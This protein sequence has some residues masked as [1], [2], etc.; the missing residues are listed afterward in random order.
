VRAIKR[1]NRD[2]E[3]VHVTA[4]KGMNESAKPR[5]ERSVTKRKKREVEP[6]KKTVKGKPPAA[7]GDK[8]IGGGI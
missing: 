8:E 4:K 1:G 7:Q 2:E 5:G 3:L 6:E